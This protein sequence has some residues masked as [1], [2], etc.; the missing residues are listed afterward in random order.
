MEKKSFQG[1]ED[2]NKGS[3]PSPVAMA[4]SGPADNDTG[5]DRIKALFLIRYP[6]HD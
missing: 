5:L 4:Q 2:E 3:P 1:S 6:N